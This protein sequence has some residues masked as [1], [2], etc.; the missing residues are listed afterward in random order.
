M[1]ID[2]TDKIFINS[3]K[4][5]GTN[6]RFSIAGVA[7]EGRV[8]PLRVR[9]VLIGWLVSTGPPG[10]WPAPARQ[11]L[12]QDNAGASAHAPPLLPTRLPIMTRALI[13]N[14]HQH[15]PPPASRHQLM[16]W[17]PGCWLLR[18]DQIFSSNLQIFFS[19]HSVY[20]EQLHKAC[21]VTGL[22][23]TAGCTT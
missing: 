22:L 19:H 15:Q 6:S 20:I 10:C 21:L 4:T 5:L 13:S 14:L 1:Q 3:L 23:V 12:T 7:A 9:G 18:T 11:Q 2:R 17:R 8:S 16:R